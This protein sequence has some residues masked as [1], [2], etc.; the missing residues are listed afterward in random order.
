M[1]EAV[2]LEEHGTPQV[3]RCVSMCIDNMGWSKGGCILTREL[4]IWQVKKK[5]HV[6]TIHL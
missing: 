1:H 5:I 3:D 6:H 2:A 4:E